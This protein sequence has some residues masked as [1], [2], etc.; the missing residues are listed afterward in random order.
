MSPKSFVAAAL[1]AMA[2]NSL[3]GCDDWGQVYE[4]EAEA[5]DAICGGSSCKSRGRTAR[6]ESRQAPN[7]GMWM[8][9]AVAS[10]LRLMTTGSQSIASQIAT[11]VTAAVSIGTTKRVSVTHSMAP[12]NCERQNQLDHPDQLVPVQVNL[13]GECKCRS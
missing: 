6:A 13:H 3:Q 10:V 11:W 7:L 9:V 1:V 8:H 12:A 5:L 2:L 4:S